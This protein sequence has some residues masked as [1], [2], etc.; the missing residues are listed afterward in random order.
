[1][2]QPRAIL[3]DQLRHLKLFSLQ[4][5][6]KCIRLFTFGKSGKAS[7]NSWWNKSYKVYQNWPARLK[8]VRYASFPIHAQQLFN[9]RNQTGFSI[10]NLIFVERC[11]GVVIGMMSVCLCGKPYVSC[12]YESL[13]QSWYSTSFFYHKYYF[14]SI[15]S[16][17]HND[18]LVLLFIFVILL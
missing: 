12:T 11:A 13:A 18:C 3:R 14:W 7:P 9:I 8:T 4:R 10:N 2:Q 15:T 5:H 1:M 6:R 17:V 16:Y